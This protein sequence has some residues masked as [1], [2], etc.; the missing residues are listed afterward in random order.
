MAPPFPMTI[1]TL[2]AWALACMLSVS[3]CTQSPQ[4]ATKGPIPADAHQNDLALDQ[5]P[6]DTA[7][8][9]DLPTDAGTIF[10]PEPGATALIPD[11]G[12]TSGLQV[13]TITGESLAAVTAVHFGDSPALQVDVI[14]DM[15]L[16]VVTPPHAVG[17]VDEIQHSTD[18]LVRQFV[19]G[20]ATLDDHSPLVAGLPGSLPA[21]VV[22]TPHR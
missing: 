18:P 7:T 10:D 12:P 4:D 21:D 14:D 13:V 11:H 1:R 19:E 17:T 6:L 20:R 16:Q 9:P 8:S 2:V 15:T 22:T 3:G 5:L